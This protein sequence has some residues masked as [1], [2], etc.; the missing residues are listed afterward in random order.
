[1]AQPPPSNATRFREEYY[2]C[3]DGLRSQLTE[4]LSN[5]NALQDR[6]QK[7]AR[8]FKLNKNLAWKISKLVHEDPGHETLSFIPGPSGFRIFLEAFGKHDISRDCL[9]KAEAAFE[10]FQAMVSRHAGDRGT[11]QLLLDSLAA[12]EGDGARLEESRRLAFQGNSGIFGVQAKVRFGSFFLAPNPEQPEMLDTATLGGLLGLRRFRPNASWILARSTSFADDDTESKAPLRTPLDPRFPGPGPSLLGAFS[13]QP[14]PSV[15]VKEVAGMELY[16]LA[17]GPIGNT[18]IG[19]VSY[20][21]YAKADVPR[22]RDAHNQNGEFHLFLAN[23]VETLI[24]DFILH[25]DL[26]VT[27]APTYS[28][29]LNLHQAFLPAQSRASLELLPMAEKPKRLPGAKPILSTPLIEQYGEMTDLVFEKLEWNPED[30]QAWR[31]EVRYP[32]LPATLIMSYPLLD[33]PK[34]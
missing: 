28:L 31:I 13:D 34:S 29:P 7:I 23:P 18:G 17:G 1:M 19:N 12:Q 4:V 25:K 20:G 22:Y 6:P 3:L 33:A 14:P 5:A 16:E 26:G 32:P 8:D 10:V 27:E 2:A 21:N 15:T 11:L 9:D 24:F 30:F